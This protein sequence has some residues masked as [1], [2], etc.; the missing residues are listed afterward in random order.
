[1]RKANEDNLFADANE[2]RGIFIVADG[3]GGH[4]AGEVASEMA[5]QTITRELAD[6][7]DL[8]RADAP[9]RVSEAMRLANR[10]VYQRTVSEVEKLG[11]GTTASAMLLS[12]THYIIGHVGDSR[13]YLSRE[14][15]LK[16]LTRDHSLV[17]EQVDAGLLTPEQ[18]R[19]HPQSNVITRCIGMG[20]EIEPD[21]LQGTAQVGDVFLLAS[22]GLTGMVDDRRISSLLLSKASPERIVNALIAEANNNGGIDN[23]T[24]IVVKVL[25]ENATYTTGEVTPVPGPRSHV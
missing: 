24:A 19:R 20:S 18:A 8:T 5:V 17:Q 10:T 9:S 3:M 13:I 12:D 21:I 6:V 22:D 2:H 23:I 14:G 7:N 1:M 16:Q 11:M 4:A 15:Q 25:P